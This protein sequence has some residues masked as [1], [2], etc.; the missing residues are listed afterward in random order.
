MLRIHEELQDGA[1]TNCTKLA[2]KL[3][4]ST[5]TVMRDLA[6]MRDQLDL[7]ADYDQKTYSW[8]Y[9][10]PVTSFPT[11]QVTEG[12]L[13]ALLVAQKALEQYKGTPYHDQLA[14]AFEK[15]SAGLKDNVSFSAS[16]SLG[17]VSFHHQGLS[18]A[19]LKVFGN[20]S[21]AVMQ[22]LEVEFSYTKPNGSPE[23]R[24]VRP[25]HLAN[26]A[27][28]WYLVGF[29]LARELLRIFAVS[30]IG[31]VAV[32]SRK[33]EKPADFSPEKHYAK[34][35]GAFVG[36]GD[37]KVVVRFSATVAGLVK[38]RVWHESSESRDLTGGR[39]ECTMQ[40]DSLDEVQRWILGWGPNAEVVS[41]KELVE[42]V[43][44]AAEAVRKLYRA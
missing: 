9:S 33:F 15:L 39:L 35:F 27:N 8:R 41:P 16:G 2:Q 40:L 25:Y 34:S 11:V 3:E 36:T 44:Q 12:E 19:D 18:K 37:H 21:R 42:S 24:R 1:F 14:H 4:V 20:L 26:R 32:T 31:S 7:P 30:R 29:D 28:S 22:S 6:F 5:K 23:Q 17:S 10:Y 13:L 38:E 43:R